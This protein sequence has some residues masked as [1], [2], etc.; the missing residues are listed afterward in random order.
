MILGDGTFYHQEYTKKGCTAVHGTWCLFTKLHNNSWPAGL[1]RA[2]M[3]DYYSP[4]VKIL[5][6]SKQG[7]CFVFSYDKAKMFKLPHHSGWVD[8]LQTRLD[9][10]P[11]VQKPSADKQRYNKSWHP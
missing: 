4:S 7:P 5:L 8:A 2:P 1:Q 10:P 11:P 6:T 3:V 9:R